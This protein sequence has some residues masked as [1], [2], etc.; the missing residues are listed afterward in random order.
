M[1]HRQPKERQRRYQNKKGSRERKVVMAARGGMPQPQLYTGLQN[2][3][4]CRILR[5]GRR[6]EGGMSVAR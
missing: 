6:S 4:S 3:L 1:G 2:R 5:E